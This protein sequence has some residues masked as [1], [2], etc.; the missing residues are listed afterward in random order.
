MLVFKMKVAIVHD[1]LNQFGGAE[2]VVCELA[3][4]FH[5]APIYTSIYEPDLTW[6]GLKKASIHTSWLQKL[7]FSHK[8]FKLLLP[9]YPSVF[10]GLKLS[11]YDVILSSSSSFAKGV[12]TDE[13]TI[14][15]CYCH[16]PTRFLWFFDD[17]VRKERYAETL[18]RLPF[19]VVGLMVYLLRN[20]DLVACHRPD[21]YIANSRAVQGRIRRI[22]HRDSFVIHPPVDVN[23]FQVNTL[24][25]GFY[26][27]VSRLIPYKRIDL[28]V[29]AFNELSLPLVIVG[30]GPQRQVLEKM[31]HSNIHFKGYLSDQEVTRYF[32]GCRAFIFPGEE[33]F[34]ITPLEANACGKPVIAYASGGAL[35]SIREGLNG[36]FFQAQ[37]VSALKEAVRSTRKMDWNPKAIRAHAE[38][39]SPKVFRQKIMQFVN[40]VVIEAKTAE[41]T[42]PQY[43]FETKS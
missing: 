2:R 39:F 12:Q 20:W 9:F 28:V 26:L 11:G 32:E 33:D 5:E 13:K 10:G 7:P 16:S 42:P 38:G 30:D 6:P 8:Y 37:T 17:Y 35:D 24:D 19:P 14:H 3:K 29:Q 22:Y 36:V 25:E 31:A 27:V 1:Y 4:L 21:Y 18:K 15:I 40:Q 34:G 23:R 43:L 41:R